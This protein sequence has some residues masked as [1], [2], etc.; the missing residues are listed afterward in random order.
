MVEKAGILHDEGR[1]CENILDQ[2]ESPP[3]ELKLA[4]N[5]APSSVVV[6]G[7]GGS[8]SSSS[9]IGGGS[10][11]GGAGGSG[12]TGGV[13]NNAA[14]TARISGCSSGNGSS[15]VNTTNPPTTARTGGTSANAVDAPVPGQQP[16]N[17]S[18]G[19]TR[20]TEANGGRGTGSMINSGNA[21]GGG[22]A[23]GSGGNG[24]GGG[25]GAGGGG[26]V[27]GSA[28]VPEWE[29]DRLSFD[30]SDRFEE[31]SLCSW[32]SEPESI[33]NNWRGWRSPVAGFGS[34]K[35]LSEGQSLL[36]HGLRETVARDIKRETQAKDYILFFFISFAFDRLDAG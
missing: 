20:A 10:N 4:G 28:V 36:F 25:G 8:S 31:D 35:K 17:N 26:R 24:G 11:S 7:G 2:S 16:G 1:F 19:G 30:D 3:R 14:S 27:P 23:A 18:G 15:G 6:S 33:C 22:S 5:L 21:A 12:T 9:S 13:G 29:E 34:S 32:S